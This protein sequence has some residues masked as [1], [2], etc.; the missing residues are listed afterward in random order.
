MRNCTLLIVAAAAFCCSSSPLI[1]A[2]GS[3]IAGPL[4]G[5]D[6]RAAQLPPPGL[7]GGMV[8]LYAEARKFIDGSGTG[9]PALDGLRLS[10]KRA[11]P[12]LLYVPDVRV[13]GGSIGIGGVIPIGTECGRLFE[14]T[15]KRC[16]SGIG[17]PYVELS[18]SRFFGTIR[19]SRFPGAYPVAEGLTVGL[20]L[21]AV[22]P[23]GRYDAVDAATQGLTIG[24]NIWDI[25]P[26]AAFTYT[27]KPLIADG[28][29][30]SAKVYW[31]NYLENRDT[32]YK[33]GSIIS[34]DFA[35]TERL[36]KLQ[37]GL[38]GVYAVQVSDDKQ[39]GVPIE[40]DGRRVETL[41]LGAVLA[42]DLPEYGA[43]FKVKALTTVRARNSVKSTG[44]SIG[45]A[46]KF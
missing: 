39:F 18:W 38:A 2:E 17:D 42:Y 31:N 29:E 4:G 13:F 32:K 28:T 20:G 3:S 41:S 15:P 12:F 1:A 22:I 11:G 40:P 25:A 30:F 33:T 44:V 36:G 14:V 6:I 27:T 34:A 16:I 46:T 35:A 21:G 26:S 23:I 7:Y 37:L 8:L 19:P 9:V 45:W 10:R 24:N 43:S 5:T